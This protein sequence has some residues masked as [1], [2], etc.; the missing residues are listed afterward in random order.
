MY[1]AEGSLHIEVASVFDQVV[2]GA[3]QLVG[4]GFDRNRAR[5]LARL[6]IKPAA[7]LGAET[8]AS[9]QATYRFPTRR[10]EPQLQIGAQPS[11]GSKLSMS[12]LRVVGRR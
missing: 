3:G 7:D 8:Y 2:A 11:I 10:A 4:H 5:L 1:L 9:A 6:A 12:R